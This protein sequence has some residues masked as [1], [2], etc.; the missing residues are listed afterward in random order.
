MMQV[1]PD[2]CLF[3]P[4]DVRD[5]DRLTYETLDIPSYALMQ[6]A[7]AAAFRIMR[8]RWPEVQRVGVVCGGGN[9]AGDGY[10]L[11]KLALEN[12]MA[13]RLFALTPIEKLK[14]DAAEAAKD[15]VEMGGE[16]SGPDAIAEYRMDLLV[17][18]MIG[19]G[20]KGKMNKQWQ[21]AIEGMNACTCPKLAL[22]IP[23]GLDGDTGDVP[24]IAVNAD[25][26]ATFVGQKQGLFTGK[27]P[28]FCGD[29][30]FDA[31]GAPMSVYQQSKVSSRLVEHDA[32]VAALGR[33]PRDSHKGDFGHVLVIGGD[34]GY[35]GAALMSAEAA[36][37]VGA[38]LIS[39][40]TR[41][42]HVAL[43]V[44]HR[45]EL[46]VRG[47]E[48]QGA[49]DLLIE[50]ASVIVLGPGLGRSEWSNKVFDRAVSADKPMILDAD[51][52]NLLARRET[53]DEPGNW[54]LTPHP[55]EA[56]RLLDCSIEEVQEDR[57]SAGQALQRK[58]G[59][60][61][62]L[63]GSGTLICSEDDIRLCRRGNPGMASGGMGDVLTGTIAGL[64]AQG[65]SLLDAASIGVWV[66]GTAGDLAAKEG[67]E[68]GTLAGDLMQHLRRLV[69]P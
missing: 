48:S 42:V 34:V 69:N 40:G 10:V 15:F 58:Y 33:R 55:G 68:R 25:V 9:N 59:G 18:A 28:Q 11:A 19:T 23:S 5:L 63:K 52:L 26:T 21:T 2:I 46:M 50:R 6:R 67:G 60:I 31:L 32:V 43:M 24:G 39:V 27:G 64:T 12:Q 65:L 53:I 1:R 7:G 51:A 44:G 8:N 37:R 4:G 29:V 66:H 3:R 22:D 20:L 30:V 54:V 13:V 49:L 61:C 17:D 36:G 45:P 16:V 35:A 56:A 14:G 41:E 38:G 62:V 57:F 47:I